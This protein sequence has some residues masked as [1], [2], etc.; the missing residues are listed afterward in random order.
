MAN[1]QLK[2]GQKLQLTIK[3]L[4]I[5][6]EGIGY[7]KKIDRL[8]PASSS[9]RRS[10][11]RSDQSNSEVCRSENDQNHQEKQRP[12]SPPLQIL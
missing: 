3:R 4:G 10:D 1:V 5:N 9:G 8:C 2:N 11:C 7:Y 6:G 12:Y